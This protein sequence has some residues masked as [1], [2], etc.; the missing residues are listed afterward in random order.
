MRYV[1]PS[2]LKVILIPGI[3]SLERIQEYDN[4]EQEPKPTPKGIPPAYWPASGELVVEGLS[5]R[6]SVDGPEILHGINFHIKSGERV[7][8]VGR[9]GSGKSSLTLALLRCIV[10]EGKVIYDGIPTSKINL[11]ALRTSITIIPQ[12]PELLSDTLRGNLDPFGQ[13]DDATLND[14]LRSAGLFS[15]QSEDDEGRIT[16]ETT[17]SSGGGNLSIGQR[18]ILALARAIVRR[19]KLL[20]LDE[21]ES[22]TGQFPLFVTMCLP[23]S[24]IATSAID[25]ETD[26]V[27]QNS[28]RA[29]LGSDVTLFTIA[30]RL[31]TI[32]DADKIVSGTDVVLLSDAR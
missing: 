27:I 8:V 22:S 32:M 13:H 23:N 19:S 9:T 4:I 14:A 21:G 28:L 12:V 5:A 24:F 18:Q 1:D 7:G 11:D 31:Q 20:I 3:S 30:H 16:L 17:I 26:T 29:N 10:T 15:V 6:Y 25:Y 2:C